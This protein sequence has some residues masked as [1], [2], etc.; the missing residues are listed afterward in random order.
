MPTYNHSPNAER[1]Y[2]AHSYRSRMGKT[3]V[4]IDCPFCG[5]TST[6]YVW[7]LAGSGKCCTNR[8]CGA[9]HT[10]FGTTIP[11]VGRE[12]MQPEGRNG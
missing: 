1:K 6:A 12:S 8:K 3:T 7:S 10:S 5:T 9:I 11:R 4:D 2:R